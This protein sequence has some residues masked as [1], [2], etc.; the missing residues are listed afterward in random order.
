MTKPW[1][2]GTRARFSALS[3]K[4]HRAPVTHAASTIHSYNRLAT[5]AGVVSD[6]LIRGVRPFQLDGVVADLLRLPRAD[7]AALA[8]RVVVPACPGIRSVITSHDSCELKD[9]SI[10]RREDCLEALVRRFARRTTS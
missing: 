2:V 3:G 10:E 8:V 9:V 4:L 5:G 1:L 6:A 7:V